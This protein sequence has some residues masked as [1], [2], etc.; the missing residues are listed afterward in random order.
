MTIELELTRENDYRDVLSTV[1]IETAHML[2]TLTIA[3]NDFEC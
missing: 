2:N 3:T 1:T